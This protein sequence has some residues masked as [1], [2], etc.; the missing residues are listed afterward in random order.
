[1]TEHGCDE[2]A[3]RYLAN[4]LRHTAEASNALL[5]M[6]VEP[7]SVPVAQRAVVHLAGASL[8]AQ[9]LL[10]RLEALEDA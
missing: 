5:D 1:M 3:D 9:R 7:P 6:T 4:A 8:A 10:A 2:S